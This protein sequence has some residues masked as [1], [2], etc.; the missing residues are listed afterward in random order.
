MK[1]SFLKV[2]RPASSKLRTEPGF[3]N[4]NPA[5][6]ALPLIAWCT[7]CV[8]VCTHACLLEQQGTFYWNDIFSVDLL[9]NIHQETPH[10]L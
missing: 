10:S 8:R 3:L 1:G 2:A 9:Q 6:L 7:I 4:P 5:L